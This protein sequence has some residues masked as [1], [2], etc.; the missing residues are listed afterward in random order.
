M[1]N[2]F[3]YF[4]ESLE[5]IVDTFLR[6]Y[7]NDLRRKLTNMKLL[8]P[9]QKEII[10]EQKEYLKGKSFKYKLDYYK[11]YY[12]IPTIVI[13]A[14]AIGL[15]SIIRSVVTA[16]DNAA[17]V[18]FINAYQAP[19]AAEFEAYLGIDT[20][21]YQVTYDETIKIIEDAMDNAT[22]VSLQK[23]IAVIAANDCDVMLGDAPTLNKYEISSFYMDLRDFLSEEELNALGD[24][25]I[26]GNIY[27]SDQN[28]TGETAPL[29]IDVTDSKVLND[30][31]CYPEVEKV[32]YSVA[33]N[34]KRP[35]NAKLFLDYL[36]KEVK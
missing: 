29:Y 19:D 21:K 33:V 9:T 34:T 14:V 3:E 30:N 10:N 22:Y 18:L 31:Y 28:P 25:V 35:E 8:D 13:I 24:R 4:T 27:D 36:L 32:L 7:D 5:T 12:L 20:K 11:Q 16:K 26:W 15:F 17:N 2:S 1:V 23:W 6:F